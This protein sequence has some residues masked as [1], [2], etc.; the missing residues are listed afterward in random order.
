MSFEEKFRIVKPKRALLDRLGS[1]VDHIENL[2]HQKAPYQDE[3][4]L[5]NSELSIP[6]DVDEIC[7]Y[8]G[9]LTRDEF[10]EVHLI[11]DPYQHKN[12]TDDEMLWL[13]EQIIENLDNDALLTY[14]SEI[15]E[16]N[17]SATEGTLTNLIFHEDIT[18][19]AEILN[20]I[21]KCKDNV[22][23]L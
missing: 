4:E 13:I 10:L 1:I 3:L 7:S 20:E 11:P 2:C 8:Y 12:L 9:S 21:K 22:I 19:P 14:Y 23:H 16:S 18:E 15:L 5:L 17:T 6:T